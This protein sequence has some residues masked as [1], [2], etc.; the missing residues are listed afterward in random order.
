MNEKDK[1][2]ILILGP[3]SL[4]FLIIGISLLYFFSGDCSDAVGGL[5]T[6]AGVMG[7]INTLVRLLSPAKK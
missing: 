5:F 7:L 6:I 3:I 2:D 4:I 1:L